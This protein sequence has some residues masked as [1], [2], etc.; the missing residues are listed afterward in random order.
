MFKVD[1]KNTRTR[2]EICSELKSNDAWRR[3]G[4]SIVT[5]EHTSHL[6]LVFLL[7]TLTR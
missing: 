4:V 5:F 7:L 6:V 3:F 2:C 1:N